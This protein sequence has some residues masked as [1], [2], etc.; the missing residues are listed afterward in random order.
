MSLKLLNILNQSLML[1]T[2]KTK[3]E[4]VYLINFRSDYHF[5][6]YAKVD[7]DFGAVAISLPKVWESGVSWLVLKK[8]S[9]F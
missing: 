2:T 3:V 6:G 4:P 5:D 9:L 8:L 7:D 1:I